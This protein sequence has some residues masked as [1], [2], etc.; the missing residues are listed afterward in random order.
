[1]TVPYL[2][3]EIIRRKRDRHVLTDDEIRFFVSGVSDGSIGEGQVAALCMAIF[4]NDMTVAERTTLTLAMRDSGTCLDWRRADL[5][6]PVL[7]KHSTGGVGDLVSLIL[8]PLLA[9]CG[10]YVPM[11]SGRGLGHTG[12]TLDKLESI[13]GFSLYPSPEKLSTIVRQVGCAIIGQTDKLAPADRRMYAIRDISGSVES[14]PLITASILAKKLAEGLDALVMD[15]KV[16][17]GA[18]MPTYQ[19]SQALAQSIA[20]VATAAGCPTSALLTDMN[21]VLAGSAGNAVEVCEAARFLRGEGRNPRLHEVTMALAAEALLNG[22]LAASRQAA[23]ERLQTVLDNGK[24]GERFERMIAVQGGPGDFLTR[25][26]SH[27][28][29]AKIV[30]PLLAPRS[31][32]LR[33]MDTRAIGLAV[34]ALGGG[35]RL[36]TDIIDHAVGFDRIL[37]LGSWVDE[38]TP[39]V[40]IHAQDQ[41]SWQQAAGEYLAALEIGE[42]VVAATPEI[43]ATIEATA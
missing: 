28:P 9:A 30:K 12:G 37:P 4:F 43:H 16:G 38:H 31:G 3:Q 25:Y 20:D 5:D 34:I 21:Q 42:N 1:M 26:A 24:A 17:N 7:D 2:P 10:G 35:R 8:A 41:D 6:G 18:F 36:A 15:V 23:R 29:R 11:I 22:K 39:L 40:D 33:A 27:L 14:I 32:T 19:A 13:P